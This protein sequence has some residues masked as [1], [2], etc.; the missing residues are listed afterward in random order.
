MITATKT[1]KRMHLTIK[2]NIGYQST[3]QILIFVKEMTFIRLEKQFQTLTLVQ[4][5]FTKN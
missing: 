3:A 2:K 1:F 5:Y 4:R